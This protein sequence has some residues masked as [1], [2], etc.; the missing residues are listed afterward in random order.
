MFRDSWFVTFSIDKYRSGSWRYVHFNCAED[1][2]PICVHRHIQPTIVWA[3]CLVMFQIFII[4]QKTEC[5]DCKWF[6]SHPSHTCSDEIFE[7]LVHK[8]GFLTPSS[9][10]FSSLTGGIIQWR[11]CSF[12]NFALHPW[13][14]GQCQHLYL[15][16]FV[17]YSSEFNTITPQKLLTNFTKCQWA[18]SGVGGFWISC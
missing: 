14:P 6:L 17:N 7:Q 16:P 12:I 2:E 18:Y 15:N 11:I 8:S 1:L 10:L 13:S 9:I 3:I 4:I 5:V